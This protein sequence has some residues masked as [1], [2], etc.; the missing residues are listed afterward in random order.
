MGQIDTDRLQRI[1]GS[2]KVL[3]FLNFLTY[4]IEQD[5]CEDITLLYKKMQIMNKQ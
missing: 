4:I 3:V 5:L 2:L 1:S